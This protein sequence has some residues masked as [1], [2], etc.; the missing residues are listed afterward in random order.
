MAYRAFV[1]IELSKETTEILAKWLLKLVIWN[2][3]RDFR[4]DGMSKQ[5]IASPTKS[6]VMAIKRNFRF[7]A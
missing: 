4:F 1:S 6:K 3:I 7:A 2:R 5:T